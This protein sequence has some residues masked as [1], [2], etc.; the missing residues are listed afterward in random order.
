VVAA[1]VEQIVKVV[2]DPIPGLVPLAEEAAKTI[3]ASVDV[4]ARAHTVHDFE[5]GAIEF[6]LRVVELIDSRGVTPP[7]RLIYAPD[8]LDVLPRHVLSI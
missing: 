6:D 8:Y 7:G 1:G 4:A 2:L 3:M 5:A